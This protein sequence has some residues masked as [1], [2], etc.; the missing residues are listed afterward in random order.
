MSK[1]TGTKEDYCRFKIKTNIEPDPC[2]L[3]HNQ[4][5][6]K[7]NNIISDLKIQMNV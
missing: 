1:N 5:R 6:N 3:S 7:E 2:M 4:V